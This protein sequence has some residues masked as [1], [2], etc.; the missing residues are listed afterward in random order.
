V[1]GAPRKATWPRVGVSNPAI[2]R[3]SVVLPQP[4]APTMQ[5][6]SCSC[7]AS[8]IP[9]RMSSEPTVKSSPLTAST[10]DAVGSPIEGPPG[11][12]KLRT[13]YLNSSRAGSIGFF[14]MPCSAMILFQRSTT[15]GVMT[16]LNLGS[17]NLACTSAGNGM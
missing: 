7:T 9:C 14:S 8:W 16:G 13:A 17:G 10:G 5:T 6:N 15:S 12:G 3:S 11:E 4:E 1:T 2:I